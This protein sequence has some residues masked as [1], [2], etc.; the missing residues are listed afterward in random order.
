[1]DDDII[2]F[3]NFITKII[4][5]P[6]NSEFIRQHNINHSKLVITIIV[7]DLNKSLKF[8]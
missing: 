2:V 6:N 7:T 1:M 3:F 8:K 4:L 5:I